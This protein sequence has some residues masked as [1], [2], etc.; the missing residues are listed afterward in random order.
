MIGATLSGVTFISVPGEVVVNW[1]YLQMMMGSWLCLHYVLPP[2]LYYKMG[3]RVSTLIWIRDMDLSIK[4]E[5][6]FLER[7]IGA[8]QAF[9]SCVG[10]RDGFLGANVWRLSSDC[11][12]DCCL[13][14][15]DYLFLHKKEEWLL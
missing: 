9:P 7:T 4:L 6:F 1:H 5:L 3:L 14:T 15:S 2:P 11:A 13:G 12:A 10:C 8:V